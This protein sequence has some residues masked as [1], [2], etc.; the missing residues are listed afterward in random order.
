M[1]DQ[2]QPQQIC[3]IGWLVCH[4]TSEGSFHK[5]ACFDTEEEAAEFIREAQKSHVL[6][7]DYWKSL[8]IYAS[9][10][11]TKPLAPLTEGELL[12][13]VLD[14]NMPHPSGILHR[15]RHLA[16]GCIVPG[17][18]LTFLTRAITKALF[19][20]AGYRD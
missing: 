1:T 20:K 11:V 6:G 17:T 16:A 5:E 3:P 14:M 19:R 10:P 9:P 2:P 13:C 18:Y 7:A 15:P 4:T 8:P 12:R